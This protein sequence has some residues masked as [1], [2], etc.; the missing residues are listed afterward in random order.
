MELTKSEQIVLKYLAKHSGET[1]YESEIAKNALISVGSANQCLKDLLV[2]DMVALT[3][4]GNMNF[5]SLNLENPL[6]R[7]FK[8]TQVISQLNGLI[9]KLNPLTDK[10]I[11]FGS[12]AEGIDTQDSDIDLAIV[13]N[14]ENK[15]R[16]LIRNQKLDRE[17]QVLIFSPIDFSLLEDKDKPLYERIQKGIVLW[18]KG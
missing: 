14:E 8:I 4:K 6:A 17:I 13:S 11:L 18:R 10:V 9:G 1:L 5:Y 7:Q 3:K 2:E 16:K 12:C 15:I